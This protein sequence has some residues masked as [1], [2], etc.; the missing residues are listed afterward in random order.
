MGRTVLYGA[1][2]TTRE[3]VVDVNSIDAD[4]VTKMILQSHHRQAH[5]LTVIIE[6]CGIQD[7][8]QKERRI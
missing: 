5:T 7:T 4:F 8:K 1:E 2:G 6:T 3:G